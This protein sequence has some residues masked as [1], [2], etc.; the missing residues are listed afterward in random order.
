VKRMRER[1]KRLEDALDYVEG[2]LSDLPSAA[3]TTEE[4]WDELVG[5]IDDEILPMCGEA[6]GRTAAE[7]E[8]PMCPQCDGTGIG[9]HVD[10]D[11]SKC[12]ACRG[13]L[14]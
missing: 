5:W 13:G 4:R 9:Q 14:L 11:K 8:K 10:P 12:G 7:P 6:L 1:M 2:R 3:R